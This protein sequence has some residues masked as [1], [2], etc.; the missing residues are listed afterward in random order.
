MD[1]VKDA[2]ETQAEDG[3]GE[4]SGKDPTLFR[5]QLRPD[6]GVDG[7]RDESQ[8]A[9]QV[10]PDVPR[11]RV[12]AEDRAEAG[13]ERGQRGTVA[14]DQKVVVLQPVRQGRVVAALPRGFDDFPAHF[15]RLHRH[16]ARLHGHVRTE[17]GRRLQTFF[18]LRGKEIEL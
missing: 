1:R 18:Q 2:G 12:D 17:S 11:F 3:S 6:Q 9:D 10:G 7:Q 8:A 15:S 13:R 16:G 14:P 4:E 5:L